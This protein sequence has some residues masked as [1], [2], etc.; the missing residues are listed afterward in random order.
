MNELELQAERIELLLAAIKV[1]AD[2]NKTLFGKKLGY[3]D[4][5]FVRQML[6]GDRAITEKTIRAIESLPKMR[7]WFQRDPRDLERF[8]AETTGS[9]DEVSPHTEETLDAPIL[10]SRQIDDFVLEVKEAFNKGLLTPSRFALLK[11]L[12]REGHE[13]LAGNFTREKQAVGGRKREQG[14]KRHSG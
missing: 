3:A 8:T 1:I 13:S 9:E 2:G 4:G 14:R 5:A 12:L 10:D 6:S 7:G 11:G